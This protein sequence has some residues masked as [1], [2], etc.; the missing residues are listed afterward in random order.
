MQRHDFCAKPPAFRTATLVFL[1]VLSLYAATAGG[2]LATQDA[3]AVFAQTRSLVEHGTL[4]VPLGI[5]GPDW[6]GRHRRPLPPAVR[7]RPGALQ[8]PVLRGAASWP[9]DSPASASVA[10]TSR[11]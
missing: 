3:S 7:H 2:S 6:P 10:R 4:D 1:A 9:S 5:S 8:R 11:S